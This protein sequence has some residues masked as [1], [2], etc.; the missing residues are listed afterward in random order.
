[1]RAKWACRDGACALVSAVAGK[2][3]PGDPRILVGER[4][5]D[6]IGVSPLPHF[7]TPQASWILLVS[8]APKRRACAVDQQGAQIAVSTFADTEYLARPPLADSGLRPECVE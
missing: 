4:D 8:N 7:P 5:S 3:A 1:V 2:Q 6:D